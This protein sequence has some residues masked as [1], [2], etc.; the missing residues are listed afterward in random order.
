MLQAI[1][2]ACLLWH[3]TTLSSG[4]PAAAQYGLW[5]P[6][7][8]SLTCNERVTSADHFQDTRHLEFDLAGSGIQYAPGDL[9]TVFPRQ[10]PAVVS[11]FLWRMNLDPD[12]W[13]RIEAAEAA[14]SSQS[15]TI[16][17]C[18]P[19]VECPVQHVIQGQHSVIHFHVSVHPKACFI[20]QH[21]E[22]ALCCRLC[23][24]TA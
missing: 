21:S 24:A 5:Q 11:A 14:G 3:A 10:S 1:S 17:V 9:L 20:R 2:A 16:Q 8:A 23:K 18:A 19:D 7:M 15:S 6:F 13:V 12:A 22:Y 4:H